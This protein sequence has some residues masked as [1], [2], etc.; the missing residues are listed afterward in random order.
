MIPQET[1][2]RIRDAAD[3]VAIIGEAVKLRKVGSDFRG[4]CPFHGGKNPNFSVSTRNNTYHCF[5]CGE[6]GDVFTFL[7]KH[8][9][10]DWPTAVR[11][12]A[13]RAGIVIVETRGSRDDQRD[14]REPVWSLL[15]AA[16]A[17]F[18]D[19]LWSTDGDAAQAYL[20]S[21]GLDR[22]A[23]ERFGIGFAPVDAD[24]L[25]TKLGALGYN[26]LQLIEAGL[27]VRRDEDGKV[28][29]RFRNRVMFPIF[30][31]AG[32]P[33][34]FGG[35]LMGPGEP[36]Y[37]NS[38]DSPVFS[39]G[40]LLYG[41]NWAKHAMRKEE[42]A[43]VVEGYMDVIRC[44]LA[45]AT[46]AVAGLGTA[47]TEGQAQLLVRFTSNVYLLYDS[48][49]AGQKAT[50]KAGIA[51]LQQKAA[52]HVVTL[53][54][55]DDPDTFVRQ[56]GRQGLDRALHGSVDI[57]E[58]QLQLMDQRGYFGD[59][60]KSRLAIDKVLP[61]L[62]A[63]TDLLTRAIYCK[64][65]AAKLGI[66]TSVI[67]EELAAPPKQRAATS[68]SRTPSARPT[69]TSPD[70]FDPHMYDDPP[71]TAEPVYETPKVQP[72]PL[73][74]PPRSKWQRKRQDTGWKMDPARP[75]AESSGLAAGPELSVVALLIQDRRWTR[76]A[77]EQID[78]ALF[79][80]DRLRAIYDV[81]LRLG[82]DEPLD[83]VE[84]QLADEFPFAH[85]VFLEVVARKAELAPA[86]GPQVL[87]GAVRQFRVRQLD[88][89]LRDLDARIRDAADA[90][91]R[92]E[93]EIEREALRLE[94]RGVLAE[95][96]RT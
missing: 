19:T 81:L 63:T 18:S 67:E 74:A 75:R 46:H 71:H 2:E 86:A 77:S 52:V 54:D 80:D 88:R 27:L 16:A 58:R 44:H 21:R 38:S 13:D 66:A 55:G 41:L 47:L 29:A 30:D 45:G 90:P 57:F 48:D 5:K 84:L 4:P 96:F 10:M 43:L 60:S 6:S 50:F 12:A 1:I 59:L 64:T 49:E 56:H 82:G 35:R 65:L 70:P 28:R 24:L 8:G 17:L 72:P 79:E 25:R 87:S 40:Q 78:P 22:V 15:G 95:R 32:H 36:K 61:T 23:C 94:R 89:T 93:L 62:R 34:G 69:R 39:K 33:V 14:A 51:L 26:E 92:R 73:D 76:D 85:A 31:A 3:L 42:Q 68:G 83:A 20:A 7:Q 91:S 9:G 53:P 11:A 37:L